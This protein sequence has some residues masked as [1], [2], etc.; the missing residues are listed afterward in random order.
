M[1]NNKTKL[2]RYNKLPQL[3]LAISALVED[4]KSK[5]AMLGKLNSYKTN[6]NKYKKC[7]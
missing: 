5:L 4:N 2:G 3:R 7:P 1:D 6:L